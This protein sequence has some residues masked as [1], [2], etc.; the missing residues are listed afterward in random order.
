[1]PYRC[2]RAHRRGM[3]LLSSL[4]RESRN[5]CDGAEVW[6]FPRMPAFRRHD[7]PRGNL[8]LP[9]RLTQINA[10]RLTR[11]RGCDANLRHPETQQ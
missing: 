3:T 10:C 2:I 8:P 7:E 9:L 1:M 6:G 4:L 5:P 11:R